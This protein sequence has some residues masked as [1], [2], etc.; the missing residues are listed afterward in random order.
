MYFFDWSKKERKGIKMTMKSKTKIIVFGTG[1]GFEK[2]L[3]VIDL[4]KVEIVAILDSN[5]SKQGTY[6]IGKKIDTPLN[7]HKYDYEYIIIASQFYNCIFNKLI[8]LGV[9]EKR[10]IKVFGVKTSRKLV[11]EI[12]NYNS[13]C[14]SI[15]KDKYLINY[16]KNYAICNMDVLDNE[17]NVRFYNFQ[18]YTIRGMDYVRISSLELISREVYERQ[19]EGAVAELGVYQGGF[20]KIINE[21]FYDRK[22]YLFDTFEG[23]T[24]KDVEYD[25]K[26]GFCK[27]QKGRFSDTNVN[28]VLDQMKYKENCIIKKGY[29]PDTTD[30]LENEVFA[31]VS[32]DADLYKPI[33]DGLNFFYDKLSKGGYIMVHDYN[34]SLYKGV[35]EAVR[36]FCN[37]RRINFFPL[38]DYQGS[39]VIMK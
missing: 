8:E 35:K 21:L 30:G 24:D 13:I 1:S 19:I 25:D 28:I 22:I 18:D 6:L 10:V 23:F 32:I 29:F 5:K 33:Y 36:K 12:F 11:Q 16:C 4:D 3:E 7:V 34:H 37:E 2:V 38:S 39:A 14:K 27:T 31:F 9:D 15:F 17:R 26:H 20:A